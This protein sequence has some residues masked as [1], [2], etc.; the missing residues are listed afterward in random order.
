M[1]LKRLGRMLWVIAAVAMLAMVVQGCN[2][3]DDTPTV[4][5]PPDDDKPDDDEMEEPEGPGLAKDAMSLAMNI[6]GAALP[7]MPA[8]TD[9]GDNGMPMMTSKLEMSD[10]DIHDI[11]GWDGNAYSKMNAAD[12]DTA[13]STDFVAVYNNKEADKPTAY[14]TVYA[15][16]AVSGDGA[17]EDNT[18]YDSI[19]SGVITFDSDPTELSDMIM[20]TLFDGIQNRGQVQVPV[21]DAGT[22]AKENEVAGT[23]HGVPGTYTC[24]GGSACT[25]M[26]DMD[27]VLDLGD[28]WTFTPKVLAEGADPH[29]VA[30]EDDDYLHFGFWKNTSE[31][32]DGDPVL[33]ANGVFGGAMM[34]V[35]TDLRSQELEGSAT[36]SGAATGKY[37]RKE[38]DS[39][40]E[41]EHLY[42]GQFT[43]DAELTAYF[44]G[45]DVAVNKQQ[46]IEGMITNF[47]DGEDSIDS[48]W[49]V[50]LMKAGFSTTDADTF[51]NTAANPAKGM[52]EGDKEMMGNWE[53]RFFGEVT[54]GEA[55][56]NPAVA[57]VYPSG[58]AGRFNGH[59]VNGHALG[60]FGAEMDD[61]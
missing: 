29:M 30:V 20:A 55:G 1:D 42:G 33:M 34:S 61:N 50:T 10:M 44:L 36:Y 4:M 48:T 22:D 35:L 40:G 12:G 23:F 16:C 51:D 24:T 46:S 11:M 41:P 38:F 58:I 5:I 3:G 39:D 37:V 17:C 2:G 28:N 21:D 53:A 7:T 13:A 57:D 47:M 18:G 52:T 59:F 54:A 14:R 25:V 56:A 6:E 19:A 49:S 45:D 26:R 27:G 43:A 60:A 8:T 9:I 15:D 32:K 31:D